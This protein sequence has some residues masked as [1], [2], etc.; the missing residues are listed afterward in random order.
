M[1]M[2]TATLLLLLAAAAQSAVEHKTRFDS[3]MAP[4][5]RDQEVTFPLSNSRQLVRFGTGQ[6]LLV[7]DV[8]AGGLYI[9]YGPPGSIEGSRFS[10]P[11]LLVGNGKEG[12]LA[13]GSRPAGISLAVEGDRLYM[14]WSDQNGAWA[15]RT[16][17]A[18]V[19]DMD[20]LAR[21]LRQA[22]PAEQ[23]ARE[24]VLGD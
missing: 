16:S 6:W 11:L 2:R 5:I 19:V 20:S 18:R 8:P 3:E 22:R 12:A 15:L 4:G 9:C 1:R 24:G 21:A 14:A 23:I 13:T 17:L 10:P 7:F